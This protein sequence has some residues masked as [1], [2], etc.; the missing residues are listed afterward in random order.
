MHP[1]ESSSLQG[2]YERIIRPLPALATSPASP[3]TGTA[4]EARLVLAGNDRYWHEIDPGVTSS[5]MGMHAPALALRGGRA[6][7]DWER[8]ALDD[9][10]QERVERWPASTSTIALTPTKTA[11]RAVTDDLSR[12]EGHA[13][14]ITRRHSDVPDF[15]HRVLRCNQRCLGTP[16]RRPRRPRLR[17]DDRSA[18]VRN[19]Y[20]AEHPQRPTRNRYPCCPSPPTRSLRLPRGKILS[21]RTP[22]GGSMVLSARNR[23]HSSAAAVSCRKSE[24]AAEH[25]PPRSLASLT[26]PASQLSCSLAGSLRRP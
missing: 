6:N 11:L 9:V 7:A 4:A 12:A 22:C 13:V 3:D 8:R 24:P 26:V 16:P 15:D 20:H 23:P 2:I 21:M 18:S 1:I 10:R 19:D 5:A 17:L 25:H 14:V